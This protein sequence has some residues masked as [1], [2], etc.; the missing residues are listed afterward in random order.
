MLPAALAVG[1]SRCGVEA[2]GAGRLSPALGPDP[3][4]SLST[5]AAW[6]SGSSTE[7]SWAALSAADNTW[8]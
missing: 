1:R 6:R 4:A 7:S 8:T 5:S 2:G 3:D